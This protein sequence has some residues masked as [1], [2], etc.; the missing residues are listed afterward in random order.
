M[1]VDNHIPKWKDFLSK[2]ALAICLPIFI[3]FSLDATGATE[4]LLSQFPVPPI[5]FKE[6]Y[7]N[8]PHI[9]RI[10]NSC[11]HSGAVHPSFCISADIL[12]HAI[13]DLKCILFHNHSNKR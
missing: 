1:S 11:F 8:T 5:H 4:W 2:I 7:N 13:C 10:V 9:N 3:Y 6:A 12:F